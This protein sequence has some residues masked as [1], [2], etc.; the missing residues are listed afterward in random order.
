MTSISNYLSRDHQ[1]CDEQYMLAEA[2]LT[3]RDW[4]GAAADFK[5]FQ[6][7]LEQHLQLEEQLMFRA[8]EQAM[9]TTTGPTAVMRAEHQHMRAI[10]QAMADA[11]VARD[12]DSFFDQADTLRMMM[13]QHNLKEEGILYPMA[14]RFLGEEKDELL[15]AMKNYEPSGTGVSA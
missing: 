7:M 6:S 11:V 10:V 14:D 15:D 3:G 5:R 9:G 8:L 13:H 4:D 2:R 1:R 12:T